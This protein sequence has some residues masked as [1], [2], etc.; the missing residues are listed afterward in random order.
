MINMSTLPEHPF[1]TFVKQVALQN[2][3]K[4]ILLNLQQRLKLNINI[5]LFCCWV[6]QT[7][8]KQFNKKDIQNI[9]TAIT[10]W[11]EQIVLTLKKLRKY[12]QQNTKPISHKISNIILEKE[13]IADQIEQLLLVDTIMRPSYRRSAIQKLIDACKNISVYCKESHH[14]MD[15]QDTELIK[16]LLSLVFPTLDRK[17]IST[18]WDTSFTKNKKHNLP[19][20]TQFELDEFL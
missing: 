9:S 14:A 8:R 2:H 16:Q 7:G 17:Q 1:C 10:P 13:I 12:L 5:L 19:S 15:Q 3:I 6:A 4:N 20:F 11:H 18:Y